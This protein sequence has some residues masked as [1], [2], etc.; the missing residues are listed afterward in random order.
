MEKLR[1]IKNPEKLTE[2]DKLI[3]DF[4]EELLYNL[5]GIDFDLFYALE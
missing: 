5:S 4:G 2:V 1:F 3:D